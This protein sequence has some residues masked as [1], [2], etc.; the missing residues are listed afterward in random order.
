MEDHIMV[1]GLLWQWTG[2]QASRNVAL[3]VES[4]PARAFDTLQLWRARGRE[5]RALARL[6]DHL[7]RDIGCSREEAARECAKPAWRA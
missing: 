3:R 5:R 4:A 6:D 1:A 7:L 2:L